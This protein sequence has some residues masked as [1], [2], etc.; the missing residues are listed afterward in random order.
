MTTQ[1]RAILGL[2]ADYYIGS[3]NN[4]LHFKIGGHRVYVD[5]CNNTIRFRIRRITIQ[6]DY[7]DLV[8]S[9]NFI[10]DLLKK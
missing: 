2:W 1:L 9:A 3:T 7:F 8:E 10:E 4:T 6:T 5:H